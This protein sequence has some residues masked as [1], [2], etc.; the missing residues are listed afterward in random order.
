MHRDLTISGRFMYPAWAPSKLNRLI[1]CGN[2]PMQNLGV[3]TF[4]LDVI[5]AVIDAARTSTTAGH[6]VVVIPNAK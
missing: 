6:L 4:P 1:E 5:E 3:Q 2:I